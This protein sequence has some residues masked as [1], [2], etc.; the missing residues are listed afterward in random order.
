MAPPTA[1]TRSYSCGAAVTLPCAGLLSPRIFVRPPRVPPQALPSRSGAGSWLAEMV[2]KLEIAM[3]KPCQVLQDTRSRSQKGFS[4]DQ[5]H[6]ALSHSTSRSSQTLPG[7]ISTACSSLSLPISGKQSFARERQQCTQGL[8]VPQ[9]LLPFAAT[10]PSDTHRQEQPTSPYGSISA[11]AMPSLE[12]CLSES[13]WDGCEEVA[14]EDLVDWFMEFSRIDGIHR[15]PLLK[16]ELLVIAQAPDQPSSISSSVA[17]LERCTEDATFSEIGDVSTASSLPST[18]PVMTCES[19][20]SVAVAKVSMEVEAAPAAD[21]RKGCKFDEWELEF[22]LRSVLELYS[23]TESPA[24]DQGRRKTW[25]ASSLVHR[26]SSPPP[27]SAEDILWWQME[28]SGQGVAR[29]RSG[30]V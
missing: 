2:D 6:V 24:V 8:R 9:P 18:L 29:R 30:T 10:T 13:P 28:A 25:D 16:K 20:S 14:L 23:Q 5:A 15:T 7:E 4:P 12:E 17:R 21:D 19:I 26:E 1:P 22:M 3:A 27:V 11:L